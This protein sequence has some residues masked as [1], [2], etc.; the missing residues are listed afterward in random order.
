MAALTVPLRTRTPPKSAPSTPSGSTSSGATCR[1]RS[2]MVPPVLH[3]RA[4]CTLHSVAAMRARSTL[5]RGW[6]APP[7]ARPRR[8]VAQVAG[9]PRR[10]RRS[11]TRPPLGRPC[12]AAL[13][14][15][16]LVPELLDAGWR[17]RRPARSPE[18]RRDHPW[19]NRAEVVRGDLGDPATLPPALEG[20]HTAYYLV[21]SM[22][23]AKD[24]ADADA[25]AAR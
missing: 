7:D 23:A 22:G 6:S 21:H 2:V 3:E 5:L 20:V 25:R 10:R 18:K 12:T 17:V 11:G 15:G 8:G 13:A 16:R 19:R 4:P 14:G 1:N 24:F 9:E